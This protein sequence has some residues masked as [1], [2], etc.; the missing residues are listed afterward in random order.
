MGMINNSLKKARKIVIKIG[1]NTL[2]KADGTQ[3]TQFMEEFAAQCAE[4]YD[5]TVRL[6]EIEDDE[7]RSQCGMTAQLHFRA[8]REPAQAVSLLLH[9]EC[10]L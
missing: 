9:D 10:R 4:L 8:R 2:A 6:V 1:S 5:I 3:N 7:G